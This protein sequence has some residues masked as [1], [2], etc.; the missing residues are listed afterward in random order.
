M[1]DIRDVQ[2]LRM[3]QEERYYDPEFRIQVCA[4]CARVRS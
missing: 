1:L 4:R 2:L 3:D